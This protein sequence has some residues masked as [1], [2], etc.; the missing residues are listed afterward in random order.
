MFAHKGGFKRIFFQAVLMTLVIIFMSSAG[1]F[2]AIA[3]YD[4]SNDLFGKEDDF[5]KLSIL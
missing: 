5:W 2:A 3:S 1:A 4:R